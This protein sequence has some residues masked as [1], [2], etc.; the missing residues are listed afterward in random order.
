MPGAP[1]SVRE[2]HRLLQGRI[3]CASGA[4]RGKVRM[5]LDKAGILDCFDERI[6]SGHD[7]PRSK[8]HP[9]VYLAAMD[10]LQVA[11]DQCLVIEDTVTGVRA[12][13]AAGATVCG[14]CLPGNPVVSPEQL[15]SAGAQQVVAKLDDVALHW[16]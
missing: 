16:R 5:Q 2:L 12:G 1:T 14:L 15:L 13:V 7:M 3:A 6:F 9:D 8:P 11:P 4:D 10:R